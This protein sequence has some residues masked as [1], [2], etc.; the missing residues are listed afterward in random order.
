M[1]GGRSSP[2]PRRR[3]FTRRC[4][5]GPCDPRLSGACPSK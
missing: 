5:I 2:G 1:G 3:D 4:A